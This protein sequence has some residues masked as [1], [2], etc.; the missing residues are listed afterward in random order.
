MESAAQWHEIPTLEEAKRRFEHWRETRPKRKSRIPPDLWQTA[1]ELVGP[2]SLNQVARGLKLNHRDLKNRHEARHPPDGSE[3]TTATPRFVEF[4]WTPP[5]SHVSDCVL[6][7]EGHEGRKLK[8]T[9]RDEGVGLD[10]LALARG[11][12]EL[13]T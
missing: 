2:Y 4:P 8:L 12:W 9:V 13:T 1:I 7:V 3:E 6:E 5:A 10:V 11:L